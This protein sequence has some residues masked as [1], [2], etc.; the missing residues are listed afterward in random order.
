MHSPRTVL[1]YFP[2][3]MMLQPRGFAQLPY[4]RW[5][6]RGCHFEGQHCLLTSDSPSHQVVRE[7]LPS[8]L[9]LRANIDATLKGNIARFINHSCD[10]GNL[11]LALVH[12]RGALLPAVALIARRWVGLI[13]WKGVGG[14]DCTCGWVERFGTNWM[15]HVGLHHSED[16]LYWT[17]SGVGMVS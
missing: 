14:I 2:C 1:W 12:R 15:E 11:R 13:N 9:T 16:L 10:G 7:T 6:D 8:G 3:E 17:V 5:L 4:F